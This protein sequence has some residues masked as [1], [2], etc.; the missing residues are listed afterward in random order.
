[1]ASPTPARSAFLT[2][3]FLLFASFPA[4]DAADILPPGFRPEP[5]DAHLLTN[6]TVVIKPGTALEH[7]SILIRNGRIVAV[8]ESIA[9]P[10][11]AQVWNMEGATVYAGFIDVHLDLPGTSQ[12]VVND[13]TDPIDTQEDGRTAGRIRFFGVP[14]EEADPGTPGP[15]AELPTLRPEHREVEDYAPK[16]KTLEGLRE[17]GFTTANVVP[18]GGILRGTSALVALSDGNPNQ[19]VLKPD[20]FQHVAFEEPRR[21]EDNYPG[22]LMGV[23][24]AIRQSLLDA[25]YYS[26]DWAHYERHEKERAR[27]EFNPARAALK[28]VLDRKMPVVFEPGSILMVHRASNLAGE[29]N[30]EFHLLASGQE[31]RRPDLVRAIKA[32]FIVPLAFPEVPKMPE[33]EDWDQLGLDTL[34]AWDWAPE[35]PAL[36]RREG[37]EV[38]LTTHGLA[39]RKDFRKN[40]RLAVDR[41]LNE[42]DALAALTTVPASMCGVANHLGTIEPGKLASLTVVDDGGY[43]DPKNKVRE[44]WIEGRR[45]PVRP[46][47]KPKADGKTEDEKDPKEEEKEKDQDEPSPDAPSR[48]ERTARLALADRGPVAEPP[49]VLVRGAT[50][51]TAGPEGLLVEADLLVVNGKIKAVG[52]EL[53]L[54]R[55]RRDD[56]MVI[57]GTG[58][59]VTPGLIDAHSHSMIL[60]RVNENTLPS[61]AMV[62]IAD[63]VNSETDNIPRQLAGGLTVASLLHGSANPM[64]G[65]NAVIKLRFGAGPDELIFEEAP[66]G[67]KFA[68]GENVKQSN[69]GEKYTRRFPQTRMGVP[70]FMANRFAAA[71]DYTRR[72]QLRRA[73]DPPVRTDL[74]LEA[75]AEILA[76]RRWVHCH[77]YR[78][79]EILALLRL[80]E[81]FGFTIGT[82]Q[83]VLEG[84]KIADEIAA[85]GAGAS[86]FSD[87]WAYKF[88]VYDAI[89]YAGS[90]MHERGVLTT[91]NSDSSDLARRMNLEAAK[92]VK[93]GATPEMEALKFVT[94]NAARQLRID[95][96]VGSLEEGKDGDFVIWNGPPLDTRSMCLQTWI[97][98]RQYFEREAALAAGEARRTER[99]ALVEKAKAVA[100]KSGKNSA[101]PTPAEE[102]FFVLPLEHR[103]D[104]EDR[105]CLDHE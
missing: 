60:G 39:E 16:A 41:G 19:A 45:Y 51:W 101:Q 27:P 96:R 68:L 17:L 65:Q 103:F 10:A 42:E 24:A 47:D 100:S 87:W 104:H 15:G 72:Q 58:L 95:A 57:D 70:T 32:S 29:F 77:S 71:R 102:Q 18:S 94:L 37:R 61:S 105:H 97:E 73:E 76:G 90:L 78:Q 83:H 38:A 91:F 53:E 26:R 63:V 25:D 1:M 79:D 14:T 36:L 67:I 88:E 55:A 66:P 34:R 23:I 54:P 22:S 46:G 20:V 28:P 89:P 85:H 4:L 92:A 30:V 62:R 33:P 50:L 86:C 6:A 13:Y 56:G 93:Y 52:K 2:A 31:W 8:K 99:A 59:H 9:A 49:A 11:D 69:W 84:Y 5:P 3:A 43:F 40:L 81:S 48:K 82:L 64:G 80:A 98:G 7:G 74:E 44:V 75:L 12:A 21:R 35:N